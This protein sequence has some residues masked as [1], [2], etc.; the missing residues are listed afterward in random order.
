M[1]YF[2]V[3]ACSFLTFP[4]MAQIAINGIKSAVSRASLGIS[5]SES[6]LDSTSMSFSD[7]GRYIAFESHS[8]NL[9]SS[10]TN[11]L[12]DI[13]VY[14]KQTGSTQRVSI[15]T[16]SVEANGPS[17]SPMISGDGNFV[18][19]VSSA[20]NLVSGD[21]NNCS[22]IFVRDLVN[23]TTIRVSVGVSSAQSDG[24][25][26]LPSISDDGRYVGFRSIA[27]NLIGTSDTND[28]I[29]FFVHDTQSSTTTRYSTNSSGTEGNGDVVD[30]VI[31]GDATIVTFT[32]LATNMASSDINDCADVFAK[33]ISTGITEVVS[34]NSSSDY[35]NRASESVDISSNGRYVV[36]RSRAANLVAGDT[37]GYAD[38]FLRDRTSGT[39][40]RVSVQSDGSQ[41]FFDNRWPKVSDDGRFILFESESQNYV[42]EDDNIKRDV[43]IRDRDS[44]LTTLVSTGAAGAIANGKSSNSAISGDGDFLGFTSFG[45]NLITSDTNDQ[46]DVF[47]RPNPLVG[48]VVTIHKKDTITENGGTQNVFE[49]KR[50][51]DNSSPLTVN[52]SL[53]GVALLGTDYTDPGSS[54]VIPAMS[55]S[56]NISIAISD[57][58]L[59]EDDETIIATISNNVNYQIGGAYTATNSILNDDVFTV[60]ISATDLQLL[61]D[62]VNTATFEVSRSGGGVYGDI[63]VNLSYSGSATSTVDYQGLPSSVMLLDG[64]SSTSFQVIGI[65]DQEVEDEETVVASI[66]SGTGY[67]SGTNDEA[68][69]TIIDDDIYSISISALDALADES[70]TSNTAKFRID[71][72]NATQESLDVYYSLKGT[73]VNGADYVSLTGKATIPSSAQYIDI[74]VTP[75]ADSLNEGVETIE[76]EILPN[77]FYG[78]SDFRQT[79]LLI[80]EDSNLPI[81]KI[82]A[83]D[84]TASE[85][86]TNTGQF[87]ITRTGDT[88]NSLD[89]NLAFG[90]NGSNGTDYQSVASSVTIP[91]TQS[92]LNILITGIEDSIVEG[93]ENVVFSLNSGTGYVIDPIHFL[94]EVNIED[95]ETPEVQLFS[96]SLFAYES[97]YQ[98]GNIK[99]QRTG[100]LSSSITVN[101]SAS[102]SAL[103]GLD[104]QS[105]GSTIVIPSGKESVEI[106]ISAISDSDIESSESIKFTILAGSGYAIGSNSEIELKIIDNSYSLI[107]DIISGNLAQNIESGSISDDGRYLVFSSKD[108]TL[109]AGD[110]NDKED[111]FLVDLTLKTISRINALGGN[112]PNGDSRSPMISGDGNFVVFSSLATNFH[113]LDLNSYEDVY[114]YDRNSGAIT[115]ASKGYTLFS[116]GGDS[117]NPHIS[118]NGDYIVFESSATNLVPGDNN[119]VQDVFLFKRVDSSLIRVNSES[120]GGDSRNAS[121]SDD[122]SKVV[123]SSYS[124]FD[125]D[126]LNNEDI[127]YV[128]LYGSGSENWISETID[129]SNSNNSG[130]PVI[131]GNGKFIAFES[132]KSKLVEGDNNSSTDIFLY[133]IDAS[134]I[135]L[136]SQSNSGKAGN[137]SS[138]GPSISDD[139][140]QVGFLSTA[141]NFVPEFNCTTAAFMSSWPQSRID[142]IRF[143]DYKGCTSPVSRIQISGGGD[144]VLSTSYENGLKNLVISG[145]PLK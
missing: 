139:G 61:E 13:F 77:G 141:R 26:D 73:A 37:N 92:S 107:G 91:A 135:T 100:D 56:T 62:G 136:L 98:D 42:F 115:F 50:Y 132:D 36:F 11:G 81:V 67:L 99:F 43:F 93:N 16:S 85:D 145:N 55:N 142:R 138:L 86:G 129:G 126:N 22:D 20:T 89:V 143:G 40:E 111:I 131:S 24:G 35:G 140:I 46:L 28:K 68:T 114:L 1:K 104:Y 47:Y 94:D 96:Q 112:E 59:V 110:S 21:T 117:L 90:G 125:G 2:I 14:D 71:R 106:E 23:N 124:Q 127:F 48:Q 101:I 33:T 134:N 7:D 27:T 97:G 25:S 128:D 82:E 118:R 51:G 102:G 38:I 19:F 4:V 57:E 76:I 123:F 5:S 84:S 15:S 144:Y 34:K 8:T 65:Q 69:V 120:S 10:D 63:E 44:S 130:K 121:I 137:K 9:V 30:G 79:S 80:R 31:S 66:D 88:T 12:K 6:N 49:V 133:S 17:H 70:N 41:A 87:T 105:I 45:S 3:L 29:D 32:S 103:E 119:S 58:G 64:I 18:V 109:V 75:I 83:T 108:N 122:G 72:G 52:F 54:V 53:S 39:I 116:N 95:N 113:S 78:I 74:E 60:E